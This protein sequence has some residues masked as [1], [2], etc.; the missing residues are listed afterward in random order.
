MAIATQAQQ[1]TPLR[2]FT[3]LMAHEQTSALKTAIELDVFTAIGEGAT[4]A[5]LLAERC[6][7]SERGMR[8]HCDFLTIQEF[9]A[10]EDS[11]YKLTPDSATFLDRQSPAYIGSAAKFLASPDILN[12]FK[13]LT[14]AVRKGGTAVGEE[15]FLVPE[16]PAW[17]EFAR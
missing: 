11:K 13:E 4:T 15:G 2:I 7:A 10:K 8:T 1:P 16:N 5:R 12:A 9:L 17:V 6:G 3:A 14:T